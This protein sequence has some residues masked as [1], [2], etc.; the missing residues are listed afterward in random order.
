MLT[1]ALVNQAD[2]STEDW[3]KALSWQRQWPA[4]AQPAWEVLELR[5]QGQIAEWLCFRAT[6]RAILHFSIYLGV[7]GHLAGHR[8]EAALCRARGIPYFE[9]Y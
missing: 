9:N 8:L 6:Q 7:A 5:A 1:T 2:T 4:N 3:A